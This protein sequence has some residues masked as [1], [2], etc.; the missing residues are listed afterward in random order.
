M[1][2][3]MEILH[4][5]PEKKRFEVRDLD[6]ANWAMGKINEANQRIAMRRAQADEYKA[7]I[8]RW[9]EKANADDVATI[10]FFE[11]E[12]RPFAEIEVA[13]VNKKSVKLLG[14]TVGFRDRPASV[15]IDDEEAAISYC[16]TF[17]PELV[18]TKKTID[19]AAMKKWL[20]QG[21][22]FDGA[23]LVP[24]GVTFYVKEA[25]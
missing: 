15:E 11:Q 25:E 3:L 6:T 23:R 17:A 22:V 9:V 8:D 7:K 20:A 4:D 1:S 2:E 5:E 21:E 12:L 19:K 24:G 14:G 10:Q 13:K 18:R 16:E